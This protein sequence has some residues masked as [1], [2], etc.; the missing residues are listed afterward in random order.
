MS[1]TS[2]NMLETTSASLP[3]FLANPLLL[4]RVMQFLS[5]FDRLNLANTSLGIRESIMAPCHR[6]HWQDLVLTRKTPNVKAL[7]SKIIL[8]QADVRQ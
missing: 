5:Q 1:L 7:S 2:T 4:D 3:L 6:R 8:S